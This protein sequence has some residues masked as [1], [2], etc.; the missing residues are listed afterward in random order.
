MTA[1]LVYREKRCEAEATG[2]EF[3][4]TEFSDEKK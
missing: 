4:G 3:G 2:F 1:W